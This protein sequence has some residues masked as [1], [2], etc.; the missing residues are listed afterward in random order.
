MK[1]T[2]LA[3]IA[4]LQVLHAADRTWSGGGGTGFEDPANWSALPADTL[5]DDLAIFGPGITANLPQLTAN[6]SINGLRFITPGGVWN[7]SGPHKLALGNAGVSS[8]GQTF[9]VNEVSADL[10]LGSAQ[11]WQA[12]NNGTLRFSGGISQTGGHILTIGSVTNHGSVVWN[13]AAGK[14]V[15]LTGPAGT[16]ANLLKIPN[17]G[18]L[19][20]GEAR[21]NATA[22]INEIRST[23][24]PALSLVSGGSLRV[25][26]GTWNFG[27]IGRN[28]L[29]D[30]FNGSLHIAGGTLNFSG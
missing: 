6:R 20:L 11:T 5:T 10:V 25:N 17:G 12:G 13:P 15:S 27:D 14:S 24:G 26:S 7:L 8:V 23:N 1:P 28:S 19:V 16:S 21:P 3:L 2:V 9:G 18:V 4:G 29:G 22:S 30:A